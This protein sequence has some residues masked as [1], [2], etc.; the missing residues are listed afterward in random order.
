MNSDSKHS[1][2]L[3]C[4]LDLCTIILV[5]HDKGVKRLFYERVSSL[6][7]KLRDSPEFQQVQICLGI[8]AL[9][10]A[11]DVSWHRHTM[12]LRALQG[13]QL[14]SWNR[15]V[16]RIRLPPAH[17]S[18]LA[19]VSLPEFVQHFSLPVLRWLHLTALGARDQILK[20][21][22]RNN[23]GMDLVS[24]YIVSIDLVH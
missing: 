19:Q 20:Y 22:Y 7:Y 4:D 2:F 9:C 3:A 5:L 10:T 12:Q 16:S 23:R 6:S 21:F 13:S 24:H 18:V 8:S 14:G 17:H 15:A 11:L 1:S